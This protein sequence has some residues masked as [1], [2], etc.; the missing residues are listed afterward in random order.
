MLRI[1]TLT[2]AELYY[3]QAVV[4]YV[5]LIYGRNPKP[6]KNGKTKRQPSWMP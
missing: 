3:I 2:L 5:R 4:Q 6:L 1:S